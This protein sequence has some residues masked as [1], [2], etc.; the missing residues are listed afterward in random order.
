MHGISCIYANSNQV[1]SSQYSFIGII[2]G[3]RNSM[4]VCPELLVVAN[5][6]Q[7]CINL[8]NTMSNNTETLKKT[9]QRLLKMAKEIKVILEKHDI[10]Y[11]ITYGTLLGAVR[12]GG[13]IP[14]DDD[15][16]FYLFDDTY[17]KAIEILRMELPENRFLEDAQSEP[18]FFHGWARVKDLNSY[19]ECQLAPHDKAYAHR[20]ISVD[21]FR[22]KLVSDESEQLYLL[23]SHKEYLDRRFKFNLIEEDVYRSR[24]SELGKKIKEEEEKVQAINNSCVTPQNVYALISMYKD[25]LYP[26]QV[27]PLKRYKF[28]DTEF[29]GPN[30][31]YAF[32]SMCY[33]DYMKLPPENQRIQHYS[34]V[35]FYK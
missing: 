26:S 2:N 22:A 14:W 23:K 3:G 28:E 19:S 16:D 12:H 21:L 4:R 20:G 24:V 33:G 5:N 15:F 35:E 27:F 9:Q 18:K 7:N 10:P 29:Y 13:F 25:K 8:K 31:A 11:F 32:L 1:N 6:P 34:A 17:D 30:D